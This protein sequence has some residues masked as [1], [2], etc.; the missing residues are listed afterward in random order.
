MLI[1]MELDAKTRKCA[2]VYL[3]IATALTALGAGISEG[4]FGNF[5][6]EVYNVTPAQRGFIEFP[7]E[8]PGFIVVV[9]I[10]LMSFMGEIRLAIIAQLLSIIGLILLGV[11]TPPFAVMLIFLFINS[12]GM[13]LYMPLKDSIGLNI[14]GSE[15]TGRQFGIMNGVRT[16][17]G[18][19][20]GLAVFFGFRHGIFNFDGGIIINFLI[21]I[22]FFAGVVVLLVKIRG[23]IGNPPINTGK[24]RFLFRREYKF[25]YFLAS[26]HGAHKQI[27]GVFGP[28][29]LISILMRQA[30]TMALLSMIGMFLGIFF[31]PFAGRLTDRFGVRSMMFIE[32]F[33]FISIYILFG[34][35]SGGLD[36]G[37]F[38]M[39]GI[40]VL[41]VYILFILDRM[42]MQLGMIRT[43]YLRTI[44]LDKSEISPTLST[45]MSLDHVIS[46]VGAFLGGLTWEA[47]GPQYVFYIAAVLSLG[48][49]IVAVK[50][51][52]KDETTA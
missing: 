21:A 42:T 46:I 11:F 5:Y 32:G 49:V 48:N 3:L 15:N 7:R 17:A 18:F 29:V 30:D 36:S 9:V 10:S 26:L 40:P 22:L 8:L 35:M 20:A 39:A 51:P 2:F 28:W 19:V 12:M 50:L 23:I 43:L 31:I 33:A 27:A 38:A 16:A 41:I 52:R 4:V 14:I 37:H 34:I 1:K 6:M 13:H 47:W 24:G 44:A 45:G 25:Y